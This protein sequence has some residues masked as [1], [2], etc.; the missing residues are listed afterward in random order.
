MEKDKTL[1]GFHSA[2]FSLTN[3]KGTTIK[4]IGTRNS[5]ECT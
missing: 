5:N 2:Q 3:V 4:N 1:L